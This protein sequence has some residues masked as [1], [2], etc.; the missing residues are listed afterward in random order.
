[1]IMN[2]MDP[3]KFI[4]VNNVQEVTSSQ[5]DHSK[6]GTLY[7]HQIFGETP[8]DRLETFG[9]I[10]LHGHFFNPEIFNR[11]IKR[12]IGLLKDIAYDNTKVVLKS[13]GTLDEDMEHGHSGI[14]WLYRNWDKINLKKIIST[15]RRSGGTLDEPSIVTKSIKGSI[16][17]YPKN[18]VF[19]DK[20]IVLPL[21]WRDINDEGGNV[22]LDDVN[23][24][25]TNILNL[26]RL[27]INSD[28]ILDQKSVNVRLQN[29]LVDYFN[30]MV[31]KTT[32]KNGIQ[33]RYMLSRGLTNTARVVISP[34]KYTSKY[35]NNN[36]INNTTVGIPLGVAAGGY[37]DYVINNMRN[38]LENFRTSGLILDDRNSNISKEELEIYYDL[39]MLI[40]LLKTYVEGNTEQKLSILPIPDSNS[41]N[42]ILKNAFIHMSY[43]IIDKDDNRGE[44]IVRDMTLTDLVYLATIEAVKDKH[45]CITR[46]PITD[47]FNDNFAR[48]HLLTI[49]KLI[50]VD[51]NG[52]VYE[53]YPDIES[54]QNKSVEAFFETIQPSNLWLPGLNGDYDGDQIE[55]KPIWSV[56]ANLEVARNLQK[57]NSVLDVNGDNIKTLGLNPI[58]TLYSLT[59]DPRE[60]EKIKVVD[61]D[62]V[63]KIL[64]DISEGEL[65]VNYIMDLLGGLNGHK[66]INV[67]DT[68]KFTDKRFN[69]K[70]ITTTFGRFL[71][72]MVV[73]NHPSITKFHNEPLTGKKYKTILNEYGY[74]VLEKKMTTVEYNNIIDTGEHML[75]RLT[76]VVSPSINIDM[77][78]LPP[79]IKKRRAE[80]LKQYEKELAAGDYKALDDI[81]DELIS[82][83]EAHHKGTPVDDLFASGA[84]PSYH[85]NFKETA[86]IGGILPQGPEKPYL[87]T[88]NWVEGYN[89]EDIKYLANTGMIGSVARGKMTATGGYQV[90]QLNTVMGPVKALKQGSD[91]GTKSY[92]KM[93]T[94][95]KRD[96][97]YRWIK[98]G[99]TDKLITLENVDKYINKDIEV[100]S[101]LFCKSK[102][103][104][105]SKCVGDL[106]YRLNDSEDAFNIG[107]NVFKIGSEVM[108]KYMK[109]VHEIG[110]QL[111]DI[112]DIT[113][114][115]EKIDVKTIK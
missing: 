64:V 110:M 57:P 31:G 52:T 107:Q 56:E 45:V 113:E 10:N 115:V 84:K 15:D 35:F 95:N 106:Y 82:M 14:D 68:V 88:S 61:Q 19:I 30:H 67:V 40:R 5:L 69:N 71:I 104:Y 66:K 49:K 38:I 92:L 98:D 18:L 65:E 77:F 73:F 87:A 79:K 6:I 39:P 109:L 96:I 55:Y 2:I 48:H 72:N 12:H 23:E 36:P 101:P 85:T 21:G 24:F 41:K 37:S 102:D 83:V 108:Q 32:K 51:I 25:Y 43:N 63:R 58:Q 34:P 1:M 8:E 13:D 90:K 28:F 47:K 42:G 80:L 86:I 29:I 20:L 9:Y 112:G 105:C 53:Y 103:G 74:Y 78:I 76:A 97:M 7:S 54:I 26:V 62:V 59:R 50:K 89:K 17:K 11:V 46:H 94:K 3:N 100:R 33:N 91:C 16:L 60:K 93:N 75:F 111:Y 81:S 114:N 22:Q 44:T 4:R 27:K 99:S 70:L